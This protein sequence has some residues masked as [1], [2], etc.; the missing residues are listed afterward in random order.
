MRQNSLVAFGALKW[1]PTVI[2]LRHSYREDGRDGGK[3]KSS[4]LQD[5]KVTLDRSFERKPRCKRGWMI[6]MIQ[7]NNIRGGQDESYSS[8][9]SYRG[10]VQARRL[11]FTL[12]PNMI[13]HPS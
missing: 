13:F 11:H 3:I 12:R 7:Y 5:T 4:G 6:L 1:P 2:M 10:K 8:D 9:K